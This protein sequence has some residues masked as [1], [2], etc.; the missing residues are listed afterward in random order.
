M[1]KAR[2]IPVALLTLALASTA[3]IA[4]P[5]LSTPGFAFGTGCVGHN[6]VATQGSGSFN[7]ET[8]ATDPS[9][10]YTV[11]FFVSESGGPTSEFSLF[12]D[13]QLVADVVNPANY[14]N[15]VEFTYTDLTA[16][17]DATVLEIHGRQDPGGINFNNFTV[18]ASDVPEPA[19]LGILGAG[20]IGLYRAR[21]RG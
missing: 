19:S 5:N 12:W 9:Q 4:G 13:G 21:R 7:S 2:T 11:D 18:T 8:I 3:A 17:S 16:S 6:C 10:T 20:L 1:F 15:N 14:A